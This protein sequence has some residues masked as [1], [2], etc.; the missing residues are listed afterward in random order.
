MS[1]YGNRRVKLGFGMKNP[2][3]NLD[4]LCSLPQV[5]SEDSQTGPN[6]SPYRSSCQHSTQ[7]KLA[8]EHA[9][10]RLDSTAKALQLSKPRGSL[11]QFFGFA[12]AAH[13]RD[14]NFLN[15]GLVKLQDVLGSVIATIRRQ[16]FGLYAESGFCL[17]Q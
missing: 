11:M 8:F 4:R 14:A 7:T 6:R 15:P 9:D 13:L 10:G 12:Q 2:F 1:S 3:R 16:L 5:V 17:A